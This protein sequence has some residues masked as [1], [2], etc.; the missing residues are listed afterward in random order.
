M[1]AS[2]ILKAITAIV[3]NRDTHAVVPF[4]VED[5]EVEREVEFLEFI[6]VTPF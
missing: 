3:S 2:A 4:M 1:Q 5:S 6:V